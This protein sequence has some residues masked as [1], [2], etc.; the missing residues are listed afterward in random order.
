VV[1]AAGLCTGS[2]V[3]TQR[4]VSGAIPDPAAGGAGGEARV[5]KAIGG[6]TITSL[7]GG[8]CSREGSGCPGWQHLKTFRHAVEV[9]EMPGQLPGGVKRVPVDNTGPQQGQCVAEIGAE[10]NEHRPIRDG[11]LIRPGSYA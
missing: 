11:L 4:E 9:D 10:V 3:P 7:N 5:L 8:A 6:T 2:D 1:G